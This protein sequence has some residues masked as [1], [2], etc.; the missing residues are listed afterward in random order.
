MAQHLYCA[1]DGCGIET[2]DPVTRQRRKSTKE[3]V[4]LGARLADYL[5]EIG[6]YWPIVSAQDHPKSAP[7]HE[8]EASYN[9]TVK[10]IQSETVMGRQTARYAVEMANVIAGDEAIAACSTAALAAGLLY[11]T[12][13][14]GPGRDGVGAGFCRG[15]TAGRFHVDGECR[16]DRTGNPGGHGGRR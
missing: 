9:N 1:T 6:F 8:L 2:I 13:G 16:F 12:V 5:P 14:A 3:D 15:R 10:H 4:G 11:C 7:L